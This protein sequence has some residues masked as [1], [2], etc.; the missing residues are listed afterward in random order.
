MKRGLMALLAAV[1]CGGV[2]S[3]AQA[4]DFYKGKTL[5]IFVGGPAGG[6][7]DGHARAITRHLKKYIPGTP[8]I[9]VLN[10]PIAAG[11]GASNH[12][13]NVAARDGTEI[14][15][16]VRNTAIWPI[17]GDDAAKWKPDQFIWLGTPASYADNAYV[18]VIRSALPYKTI[19]DLRKA[20]P[21]LAIGNF[22]A[23]ITDIIPDGLGI[24]MKIIRGY[25]PNDLN[26][27]VER[28]ELDGRTHSYAAIVGELP[29]WLEKPV[30][31]IVVQFGH[32]KRLP[33][34][35]DVPTAREL[36]RTPADRAL[37]EFT[38]SVLTLGYPIA[39]PPGVPAEQIAILRKGLDGVMA[40]PAYKA[41][42]DKSKMEYSPKS[43]ASL[44]EEMGKIAATPAAVVE[45]Y[46]KLTADSGG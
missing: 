42:L 11:R 39:A 35:P 33:V 21:P 44:G 14:G 10:M 22:G 17:L 12:L 13:F 24:P 36:A 28:G 23:A 29:Q 41:E 2:Y 43:G 15:V 37:I 25:Q 18:F 5:K 8:S 20:N 4:E 40:D 6:T 38:E 19:D 46:K 27:A 26:L 31:R 34:M 7:Y 32:D 9:V 3:S 30:V 1:L 45:R 16:L